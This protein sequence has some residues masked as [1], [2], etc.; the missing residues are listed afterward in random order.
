MA[1]QDILNHILA[2]A[3]QKAADIAAAA[4]AEADELV[5]T[6]ESE[7]E[8]EQAALKK[9]AIEKA[10]QMQTKVQNMVVHQQK[11]QTLE[12]KRRVVDEVFTEALAALQKISNAEKEHI[13]ARML[14]SIDETTGAIHP[15]QNDEALLK[16]VLK[17][18]G[19]DFTVAEPIESVGG[20]HFV[21]QTLE[22]D[23]RFE[24]VLRTTVRPQVEKEVIDL[25]F[26]AQK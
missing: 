20:F 24:E 23:F 5:K 17:K 7:A 16:Q 10:E 13:Y 8:A 12:T 18:S 14:S 6:A 22:I 4:Q 2:E 11:S 25:L 1:L 19:K 15:A 9:A 21:G 26:P 3:E